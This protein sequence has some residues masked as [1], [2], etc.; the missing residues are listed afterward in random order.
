MP[1]VID[2]NLVVAIILG[3]D[4]APAVTALISQWLAAQEEL[5]APALLPYEV[6]N[7]LTRLVNANAFLADRISDAWQTARAMPITYH[8]LSLDGPDVVAVALR[9]RRQSAYAAAYL[10][11]VERLGAELW[12]FDGPLTRNAASLGYPV[13]LV[14]HPAASNDP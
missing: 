6:A 10:A 9:L 2:A 3:D 14:N 13:N 7:A 5:H 4:R 11:L 12:T 8:P 1:V